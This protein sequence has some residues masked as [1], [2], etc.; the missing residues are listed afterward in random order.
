MQ[1]GQAK[2]L[3]GSQENRRLGLF[4]RC[5]TAFLPRRK[6][7][8][9]GILLHLLLALRLTIDDAEHTHEAEERI[10]ADRMLLDV[11]EQEVEAGVWRAM[12]R[13]CRVSCNREAAETMAT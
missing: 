4:A 8:P 13:I 12:T 1:L 11:H 5:T 7:H 3:H 10:K 2:R 9:K 6:H